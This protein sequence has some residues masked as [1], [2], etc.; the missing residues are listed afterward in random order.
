MKRM[1]QG[2]TLIELMIVIA[3]VG[4]LAAVA[5]P[6]YQDYT[7]RAKLS[8]AL[9]RGAEVKT[10]VTEY[11][12]A[13][14]TFPANNSSDI[15]NTA[16]AGRVSSVTWNATGASKYIAVTIFTTG[17]E[18]VIELSSSNVL[19]ILARSVTGGVINWDCGKPNGVA[20]RVAAKYLPGS[21]K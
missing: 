11:Y 13:T 10:A 5:L 21:C 6:A 19:P 9:A 12:S 18:G 4:I 8:E 20:N 3:I 7:V 14:G 1:Q 17:T 15:F 16:S 2:F